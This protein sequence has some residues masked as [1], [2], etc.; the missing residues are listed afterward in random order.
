MIKSRLRAAATLA[1]AFAAITALGLSTAGPA[2]AHGDPEYLERMRTEHAAGTNVPGVMS[3]N[4]QHVRN[5]PGTVGIS[6]CF[7]ESKPLF[8]TSGLESVQVFNVRKPLDPQRVGVLDNNVFE[9]EAMNCGERRTKRGT[10]RFVLIGVDLQQA[11]SDDIQHVNSGEGQ[12]LVIVDVTNPAKPRIQSRVGATT[13][14]HTVA[15]V[16]NTDCRYAYSSGDSGDPVGE[17]SIFDLRNLNKPREVDSNPRR[18]GVQSFESPTAGHKWNFDNARFGTHTGF[19]GSSMFDV[20]RPRR[21]ELVT[22]TGRAGRGEKADGT[23]NGYNDF[24]HHN[25]FRPNAR[26]FKPNRKPS[27]ANGNILLVTEEDYVQTD[28]SK[29]G[30]FQTWHVKRLNGKPNAIVPLDKVELSD[31]ENFPIPEFAFCSAHWF[32]Y[33]PSGIVTV[34][35]YGGGTQLVDVRKPRQIKSYGHAYWGS[36]VWDSYWVPVYNKRGVA[37]HRKTNIA[38]SVDLIRGLDVY[39]VDLPGRRGG[40]NRVSLASA[41][42]FGAFSWPQDALPISLITLGFGGFLIL[43][44]RNA[45]AEVGRRPTS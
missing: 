10:K 34:G 16:V 7:M 37:T 42:P 26:A 28:C 19:D 44:R 4:V 39:A 41:N 30:S 11:S 13:G 40:A 23:P 31:L 22:T 1:T 2:S 8:V 3:S 15:C 18:Q 12:E 25:S 5:V 29:A 35:F 33:H 24:I 6:G 21:P 27:F 45:R 17:F 43:R 9:N 14:T 32:D 36:Q 38:Y 20:S